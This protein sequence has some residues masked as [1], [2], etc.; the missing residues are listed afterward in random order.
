M[1]QIAAIAATIWSK[2]GRLGRRAIVAAVILLSLL[3]LLSGSL[4][5][6]SE[7]ARYR[8]EEARSEANRINWAK[9]IENWR[10]LAEQ[11]NADAQTKLGDIYGTGDGVPQDN[12][13]AAKWYRLA[14]QQGNLPAQYELGIIYESGNGIP[15]DYTE[16]AKWFHLVA[17][18]PRH[19]TL[20]SWQDTISFGQT[21]LCRY[22]ANGLGVPQDLVQAYMWCTISGEK[23]P[24]SANLI[25]WAET[26]SGG[27]I[28][29]RDR[30]TPAM[31]P[32]QIQE[33]R[34][35]AFEWIR[36]NP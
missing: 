29:I 8:A 28:S 3:S 10:L 14:A 19:S 30:I 34:S 9:E 21:K 17:E 27:S 15:Q 13:E 25:A 23:L 1:R 5:L 22:Y 24:I 36:E 6:Y 20:M 4:Y 11:G 33:A 2:I 18:A 16:A 32:D 26:I 35:L 31:T 7:Y 12:I